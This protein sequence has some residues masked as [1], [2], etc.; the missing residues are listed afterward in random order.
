M[1][2]AL[3]AG[4]GL[5]AGAVCIVSAFSPPAPTSNYRR[6][7]A[8]RERLSQRS[9]RRLL[10]GFACGLAGWLISG[11][12]LMILLLP[13]AILGVPRLLARPVDAANSGMIEALETWTRTLNSLVGTGAPIDVAIGKS[14]SSTPEVLAPI[15]ARLHARLAARQS[16]DTAARLFAREVGDP[17]GDM[18]ASTLIIGWHNSAGGV[19]P[20]LSGLSQTMSER[21]ELRRQI[22]AEATEP[23][24]VATFM[25]VMVLALAAFGLTNPTI[26]AAYGTPGG[27]VVLAVL[28]IAFVGLLVMMRRFAVV[29]TGA[30]LLGHAYAGAAGRN[31]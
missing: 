19:G 22:D 21:V 23:R 26:S 30:R 5:A 4:A 3:L 28:S 16:M 18:V 2:I 10:L 25:T 9:R 15:V 29:P 20:A 14:V 31:Q 24:T 17:L 1:K 6:R 12:P 13:A 11:I 8:W 7:W 27:Q